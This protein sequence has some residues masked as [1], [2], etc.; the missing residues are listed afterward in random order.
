DAGIKESC[1]NITDGGIVGPKTSSQCG[2]GV[3]A[4][5]NDVIAPTGGAGAIEYL[6]LQSTTTS[7]YTP[8]SGAW[9]AIPNSNSA[10]LNPGFITQS[11]W[12]VRCA[13]RTGCPSYPGESNV[14]ERLVDVAPV[15]NITTA[16]TGS[17]C[18]LNMSAFAAADAGP[19]ATY[20]WDF[21][22]SAIPQA[23]TLQNTTAMWNSAGTKLVKLTVTR[24]ACNSMATVNVT[25]LDCSPTSLVQIIDL[26]ANAVDN[27]EVSLT[28]ETENP[29]L[30]QHF[31]IERSKDGKKFE[32]IGTLDPSTVS[33]LPYKFMD[34][35]P[36][37][38]AGY[39]R[40][41][42]VENAGK[43]AYSPERRAVIKQGVKEM[44]VYPNP[45]VDHVTVEV[46]NASKKDA[47]IE[48]V[49]TYGRVV[50]TIPVAAGT[51]RQD[52]DLSDLPSAFYV[53][54]INFE[55]FKTEVYKINKISE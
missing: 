47:S 34:N 16:P 52:V 38:G 51:L 6:W 37:R 8:G 28:W 42:H 55:G 9:T 32:T 12:Y 50:K 7:V 5:I 4:Q 1:I 25:V 27:K 44:M 36:H 45:F 2:P 29:T 54:K 18:K 13:R 14:A 24:G 40:I 21:G 53:I 17:V 15:A 10:N 39:Y 46:L 35:T 43:V 41:K 26:T 11:T 48:I 33:V 19:G 3:A 20:S 49:D 31:I 23:S 30:D 22:P